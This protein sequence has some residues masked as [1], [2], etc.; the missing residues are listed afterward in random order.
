VESD[1]FTARK[2]H[3]NLSQILRSLATNWWLVII[4]MLMVTMTTVSFYFITAYTPTFGSAVL[5]LPPIFNLT[6]TL[7][8][9]ASNLFWLPVSGALSDRIGRKPLLIGCTVLMLLT[10]YVS[11]AWLAAAPSFLRLLTVQLWFSF[12]YGCYNGA[13]VVFLTEVMPMEVRTTAFSLAYSL[14]T[15][16]F[17]GFTPAISTYL[18]HVTHNRAIPAVWLCFAAACGL[19]AT[20]LAKPHVEPTLEASAAAEPSAIKA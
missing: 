10:A 8:V 6:V 17:G 3:P 4:G 16:L 19:I 12:L 11:L 14:A 20:L 5:K 7:C 9:G 13:L 15:A 1:E 2:V 18:I